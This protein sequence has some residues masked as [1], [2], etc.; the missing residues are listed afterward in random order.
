MPPLDVLINRLTSDQ[1]VLG[2]TYSVSWRHSIL[3]SEQLEDAIDPEVVY[4]LT[5]LLLVKRMMHP[6]AAKLRSLLLTGSL[7]PALLYFHLMSV[8]CNVKKELQIQSNRDGR[9]CRRRKK[10]RR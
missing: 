9:P 6:E 10:Q 2:M 8:S 7:D 5:L 3:W 4:K 1:R